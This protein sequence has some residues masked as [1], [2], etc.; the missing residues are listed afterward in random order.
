MRWAT[1]V[2]LAVLA[3][4]AALAFAPRAAV[5]QESER[6]IGRLLEKG[7]RRFTE[8][9]YREA[10]RILAPIPHEAT[11]TTAQKVDALELIGIS[12]LILGDEEQAGRAFGDLLAIEPDHALRFDDG[13]PKI[14]NFFDDVRRGDVRNVDPS[15]SVQIQHSAPQRAV[16]GKPFELDA[17]ILAGADKAKDVVVRWRKRG[18][19]AY[20]ETGM[21]E[22]KPGVWRA[23]IN[24]PAAASGYVLDYYIE[25]RGIANSAIGRVGAPEM[26]L[27]LPVAAGSA[28]SASHW[29]SRWYVIAGG[30][31]A[32][33]L[34]AVLVFS[35]GEDAPSGTLD[36]GRVTLTP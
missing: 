27:G 33:T 5:A 14:R 17:R 10:I 8:L 20:A 7:H 13:S 16:G 4:G 1:T 35:A 3:A 36:P 11:A 26:P 29:Y 30:A 12:H 15:A 32:I 22:N 9:E 2:S 6:D 21:R 19:G 31:A 23:A 18:R 28:A 25:V 24:A 34:G